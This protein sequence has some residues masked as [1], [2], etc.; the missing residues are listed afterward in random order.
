M[1]LPISLCQYAAL[2]RNE[3]FTKNSL[4]NDDFVFESIPSAACPWDI[5]RLKELRYQ[6]I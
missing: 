6:R 5:W 1:N 4:S 3:K 2:N